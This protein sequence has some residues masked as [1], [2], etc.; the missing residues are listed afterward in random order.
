MAEGHQSKGTKNKFQPL[1]RLVVWGL[2]TRTVPK[3]ELRLTWPIDFRP[4]GAVVLSEQSSC[5]DVAL[6][7]I[8]RARVQP[9]FAIFHLQQ[10]LFSIISAVLMASSSPSTSTS[11]SLSILTVRATA[12]CQ[13]N[14]Q[15][16]TLCYLHLLLIHSKLLNI[17]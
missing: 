3:A 5:H 12:H 2:M 6:N 16:C 13:G 8:E 14:R 17:D 10:F 4:I 1:V 15:L 7:Y 11:A 9:Q